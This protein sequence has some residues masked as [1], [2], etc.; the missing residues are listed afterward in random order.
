MGGL[1]ECDLP[2]LARDPVGIFTRQ[3]AAGGE[4]MSATVT[5][6]SLPP[7]SLAI[8]AGHELAI[9]MLD[10]LSGDEVRG[11]PGADQALIER[12]LRNGAPYRD[13][14]S[15]YLRQARE[16]GPDVEHGFTMIVSDLV[17]STMQGSPPYSGFYY[18]QLMRRGVIADGPG[19]AARREKA[20]TLRQRRRERR[21]ARS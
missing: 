21:Q 7:R 12:D 6:L 11:W 19:Q 13:I 17:A 20:R 1:R 3:H 8:G 2:G 15:D 9:D 4:A 16:A 14:V 18:A 10:E 5:K